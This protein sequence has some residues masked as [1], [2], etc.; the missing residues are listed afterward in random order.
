MRLVRVPADHHP[1]SRG[2]RIE[3]KSLQIM[4]HVD[5]ASIQLKKFRLRQ[6]RTRAAPIDIA[7]NRS[8]RSG[9]PKLIED[10]GIA[11]V[12]SVEDVFNSAKRLDGLR[13]KQAMR[14]GNQTDSHTLKSL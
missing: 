3:V 12:A 2:N 9:L 4:Q 1:D 6:Q 5:A 11:N 8:D 13:P 10:R 14:V 7:P